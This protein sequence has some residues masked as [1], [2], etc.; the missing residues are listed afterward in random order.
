MTDRFRRSLLKSIGLGAASLTI[1]TPGAATGS[2]N[3]EQEDKTDIE[4]E[5]DAI[6]NASTRWSPQ[7]ISLGNDS[8]L[9]STWEVSTVAYTVHRYDILVETDHTTS[10]EFVATNL[11]PNQIEKDWI[12]EPSTALGVP[13]Y[14]FKAIA[15][16]TVPGQTI[17]V[18][19]KV[20]PHSTGRILAYTGTYSDPVY[21][22]T[23][24]WT[25]AYL[26][27]E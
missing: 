11:N 9:E 1:A 19:S 23:E 13:G 18:D 26:D 14:H 8:I 12:Y 4:V 17:Y 24:D 27:V 10:P 15:G 21:S 22:L 3:V 6:T 5:P 2:E 25:G 20:E 16:V 7:T